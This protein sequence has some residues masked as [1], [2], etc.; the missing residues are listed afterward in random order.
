MYKRARLSSYLFT[1]F[2]EFSIKISCHNMF[3]FLKLHQMVRHKSV[4]HFFGIINHVDL[5]NH[6]HWT[7]WTLLFKSINYLKKSLHYYVFGNLRLNKSLNKWICLL[8]HNSIQ[9]IFYICHQN[10][11]YF[12]TTLEPVNL[13]LVVC[14]SSD[15]FFGPIISLSVCLT[16]YVF[17]SVYLSVCLSFVLTINVSVCS[18]FVFQSV[19]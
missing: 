8:C 4:Q 10:F 17:L 3:Q 6:C 9:C 13:W 2:Q 1:F 11:A 19:Y 16:V 12:Y 18:L 7:N 14:L 5:I 15:K